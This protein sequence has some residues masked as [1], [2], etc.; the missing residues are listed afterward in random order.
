MSIEAKQWKFVDKSKW[1]RGPW[2]DEPDK[3]QWQDARS[4]LACLIVRGPVGALCGYVGVPPAHP[5]FERGYNDPE[6]QVHGGLTFSGRC[7][8]GNKEHGICH[9]AED[10]EDEVWWFGFDC[11]HAFDVCP[12]YPSAELRALTSQYGGYRDFAYVKRQCESLASQLKER[13]N[14]AAQERAT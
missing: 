11:A 13:A 6:L 4:G 10:P 14:G 9:I 7:Q 2:D 5:D 1:P 8:E 3:A 12:G